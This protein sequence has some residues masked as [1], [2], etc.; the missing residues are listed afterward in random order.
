MRPQSKSSKVKRPKAKREVSYAL[1]LPPKLHAAM[2]RIARREK[3]SL[4]Y[5]IVLACERFTALNDQSAA[6]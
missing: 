3:R 5:M 1:R 6:D 2:K 4:N